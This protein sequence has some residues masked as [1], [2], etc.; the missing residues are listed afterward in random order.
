M[1]NT[2]EHHV[3][4]VQECSSK[5]SDFFPHFLHLLAPHTHLKLISYRDLLDFPSVGDDLLH[6]LHGLA[7]GLSC[8]S[9]TLSSRSLDNL[10]LLALTH[11]HRHRRTLKTG[12]EERRK[13]EQTRVRQKHTLGGGMTFMIETKQ[14]TGKRF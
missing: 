9:L 7:L 11:L 12:N 2:I 8:L 10:Y 3:C 14:R 5:Q 1:D 6:D 13:A 4:V